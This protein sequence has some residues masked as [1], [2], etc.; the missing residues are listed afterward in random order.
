MPVNPHS[1]CAVMQSILCCAERPMGIP[2]ERRRSPYCT[3]ARDNSCKSGQVA[4][5]PTMADS[6]PLASRIARNSHALRNLGRETGPPALMIF[7]CSS[8]AEASPAAEGEA[9]E[10][11]TN[12]RLVGGRPCMPLVLPQCRATHRP[13]DLK[14]RR[15]REVRANRKILAYTVLQAEP[16]PEGTP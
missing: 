10:E 16:G 4:A 13:R 5:V 7:G 15:F 1:I 14:V 2:M 8:C 3:A 11:A 9:T 12:C 6:A